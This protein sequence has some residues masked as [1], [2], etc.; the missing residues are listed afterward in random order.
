VLADILRSDPAGPRITFYEDTPG[1]TQGERI[2]LSGKVLANWVSKAGNA[3]QDEYDLGPGSVVRLALPPHWRALYWAFAVWSVG[4]T[5]DLAGGSKADL[6][7]CDD[8][9]LAAT[10][11]RPPGDVVLVTLAALARVNPGPVSSAAMDEARELATYGDQFVARAAPAPHD[12]ALI[13]PSQHEAYSLVVPQ[14]DWPAKARVSV[15]GDLAQVLQSTLAAW[16]VDGSVVLSRNGQ[17]TA[18]KPGLERL[19]SEA[20]TLDLASGSEAAKPL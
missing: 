4:A 11:P 3:L 18:S 12:L 6:L 16:A 8:P 9:D 14:R 19:A 7:V 15:V 5:L 17:H 2:E 20:V 10:L 1:P 13:T